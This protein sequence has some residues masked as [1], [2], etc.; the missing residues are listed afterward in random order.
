MA[1]G[2]KPVPTALKIVKGTDQK[3]RVNEN[4]PTPKTDNIKMPANLSPLAQ[5]QWEQIC[6]QLIDA[7]I[8]TNIDVQALAMYCEA[9]A[10]W[11][12]ATDKINTTGAV[13]KGKDGY[14]V[15]SP[16]LFVAQKAFEQM[17]SMLTEFGMT[18]SSRAKV[19]TTNGSESAPDDPWNQF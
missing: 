3:C 1:A 4:E 8:M 15:R 14:P 12:D 19:S 13:V 2:R 11:R 18:P 7:R 9:Y 10:L 16:F 17:K 6:E 5:S